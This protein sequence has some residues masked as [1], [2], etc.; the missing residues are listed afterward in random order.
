MRETHQTAGETL[1]AI[2]R[3]ERDYEV[4]TVDKFLYAPALKFPGYSLD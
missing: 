1:R 4:R 3:D 2:V